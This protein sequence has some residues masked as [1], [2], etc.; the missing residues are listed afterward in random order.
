M[1]LLW[2]VVRLGPFDSV[3]PV[4]AFLLYL[5]DIEASLYERVGLWVYL[6][7]VLVATY[8]KDCFLDSLGSASLDGIHE[9]KRRHYWI[10]SD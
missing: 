6:V 1:S 8:E 2:F 4:L 9:G 7:W 3:C 10:W 5:D